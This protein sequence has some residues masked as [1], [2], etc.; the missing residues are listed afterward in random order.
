M[1]NVSG[2]LLMAGSSNRFSQN[3]NKT[4]Y[5][6]N[7][8]HLFLY[9]LE[10]FKK[11]NIKDIYLVIKKEEETNVKDILDSTGFSD[12][13]I[14]F[15]GEQRQDSV[16]NALRKVTSEYVLIHDTA[17]PLTNIEDIS[18]LYQSV[19][20]EDSVCGSLYHDVTDTIKEVN[21]KVI[22]LNRNK[23]KAVTTPQIF[24]KDGYAK[25]LENTSLVTDELSIFDDE[26]ITFTKETSSNIKVTTKE[27]LDYVEYLL[28][29]DKLYKIGHSY[30]YHNF[31]DGEKL[32]L[33]G[34]EIP[35]PFGLEGYSDADVVYHSV[36]E[37]ILGSLGLGDIGTIFPDNAKENYKRN[38]LDFVIYALNKLDEFGYEIVN[39]DMMIYLQKPNLKDYKAKIAS[40]LQ[41]VLKTSCVN[42]K[43]TTLEKQG[44]IGTCKG[45]GTETVILIRKT[46]WVYSDFFVICL[47]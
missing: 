45:I 4:L 8:K 18:N 41:K 34:I 40:N 29:K 16:K 22:H 35:S 9:S 10:K 1:N 37:A 5:E 44:L 11:L 32:I 25:I 24:R 28:N 19:V 39:L 17:R 21:E 15:G 2:I 20:K 33:G 13:N 12:V 6:L 47:Y 23:L 7:N 27:D 26:Q 46:V 31:K 30:D 38:S 3:I 36:C 43:A 14:I 42:V